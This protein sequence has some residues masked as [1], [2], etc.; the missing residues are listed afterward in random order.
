M[1]YN[2]HIAAFKAK[3]L[4]AACKQMKR[5]RNRDEANKVY[6]TWLVFKIEPDFIEAIKEK[7]KE[8]NLFNNHV[9]RLF[10]P[11]K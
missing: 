3:A 4:K 5:A 9:G 10:A 7:Q 8:F 11:L 2:S 1:N 6:K